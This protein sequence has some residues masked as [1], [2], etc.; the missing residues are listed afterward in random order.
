LLVFCLTYADF[1]H[2]QADA[3]SVRSVLVARSHPV[4]QQLEP[5]SRASF[6]LLVVGPDDRG[7]PE[8]MVEFCT[9]PKPEPK[10]VRHGDF[11]RTAT[12]GSYVRAASDGRIVL[13]VPAAAT[14]RLNLSIKTDGFG[15]YWTGWDSSPTSGVMPAK[16][17]LELPGSQISV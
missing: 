2:V 6:E 3:R 14:R 8:A 1:V 4:G 17:A 12:Y 15:P 13:S 7:V 11:V 10:S 5:S 9:S 16:I